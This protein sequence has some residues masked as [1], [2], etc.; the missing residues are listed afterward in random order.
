MFIYIRYKDTM[1]SIYDTYFY[2][3]CIG[4]LALRRCLNRLAASLFCSFLLN[5]FSFSSSL[6]CNYNV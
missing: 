1:P 3:N 5:L 6:N 4:P 2:N